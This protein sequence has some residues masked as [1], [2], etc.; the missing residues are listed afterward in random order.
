MGHLGQG[1]VAQG[2]I[3]HILYKNPSIKQGF[4][5]LCSKR[6]HAHTQLIILLVQQERRREKPGH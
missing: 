1:T 6:V 2:L 4:S 3:L 5:W